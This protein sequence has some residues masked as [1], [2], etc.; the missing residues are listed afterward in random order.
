MHWKMKW[1]AFLAM[2][3]FPLS[4]RPKRFAQRWGLG[5]YHYTVSD[6]TFA[7]FGLHTDNF[8][9]VKGGTALEFGAGRNLLYPLLLRNAGAE[10]VYAIDLHRH[11]TLDRVN[12]VIEQLGRV[13]EGEWKRVASFAELEQFYGI[14]YLAPHD[15]RKTGLAADSINFISSTATLEHIPKQ[16]I[17]EI[18]AEC[19]RIL[20]P[21]GRMSHII[22]YH[23]HYAS[24][25]PNIG[26]FNFYK[27]DDAAWR[28]Y[29]CHQMFHNRL[30]H[31]EFRELLDEA[32]F[33]IVQDRPIRAPWAEQDLERTEVS[34]RFERFT[35]D[36]LTTSSGYFLAKKTTG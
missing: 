20:S 11:A 34:A 35:K 26:N 22:D 7:T 8:N 17:I 5:R 28:K 21:E 9:A 13:F 19:R 31:S 18:F 3:K 4:D 32:G 33:S 29:D 1:L 12:H 36:D 6:E 16:S 10:K 27:Y 14:V 30:R 24:G 15:A 25:D 23:D 2:S